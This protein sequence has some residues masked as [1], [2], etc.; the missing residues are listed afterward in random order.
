M[1]DR[2][3]S[4]AKA[5]RQ[6]VARAAGVAP[7]TVSLVLNGHGDQA[8]IAGKTQERVRDAAEKLR[9][10][11]NS[12]ARAIAGSRFL[13]LGLITQRPADTLHAPVFTELVTGVIDE[14]ARYGHNVKFLPPVTTERA[15]DVPATLQDAHVDAIIVQN[16]DSLARSLADWSVPVVF[17]GTGSAE[18]DLPFDRIGAVTVDDVGGFRKVARHLRGRGHRRVAVLS[19]ANTEVAGRSV[20]FVEEFQKGSKLR[21][22]ELTECTKWSAEAARDATAPLLREPTPP[23]AIVGGNDWMAV[24]I[25][26]AAAEANVHVPDQLEVVGFGDFPSV[27]FMTPS[28]TTVHWP[29]D[30][31]GRTAVGKLI[32]RLEGRHGGVGHTRIPTEVVLRESSPEG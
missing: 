4:P 9:Y 10:I 24:G 18:P 21:R 25:C 28:L 20:A 32:A 8:R 7:S 31:L 30:Q 27:G 15:Y 16:I 5:S 14:A 6:D 19:P 1:G 26:R 29:L 22:A 13:T 2:R 23:T 12:A 17:V 11:P 3:T